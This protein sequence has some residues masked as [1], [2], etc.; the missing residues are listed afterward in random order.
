MAVLEALACGVPAVLSEY[1]H[2]PEIASAGAGYVVPLGTDALAAALEKLL[3]DPQSARQMGAAGAALVRER[4]T[5]PRIAEVSIEAY[6][7]HGV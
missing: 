1:C 3:T 7:R 6:R 4:Y 5:W 2:F